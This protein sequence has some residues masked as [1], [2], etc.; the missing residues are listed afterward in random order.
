[1]DHTHSKFRLEILFDPFAS[2]DDSQF[3]SV[4]GSVKIFGNP[5]RVWRL[6]FK[7]PESGQDLYSGGRIL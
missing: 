3:G 6:V 4:S 5:L 7:V 2:L 1:M